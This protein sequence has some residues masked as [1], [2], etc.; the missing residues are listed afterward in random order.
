MEVGEEREKG[1]GGWGEKKTRRGTESTHQLTR[2]K[3]TL[4]YHTHTPSRNPTCAL[5]N[6]PG[7]FSKRDIIL[8][9]LSKR[10]LF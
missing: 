2:H 4:C 8:A 5:G 6:M 7:P 9:L 10:A 1:R 3:Q